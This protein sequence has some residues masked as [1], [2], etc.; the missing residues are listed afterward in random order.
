MIFLLKWN[1]DPGNHLSRDIHPRWEVLNLPF[2]GSKQNQGTVLSSTTG[3]STTL[4]CAIA[5]QSRKK[6]NATKKGP[7]F[8]TQSHQLIWSLGG[9]LI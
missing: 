7:P 8:S 3:I 1:E 6:G 5:P 4:G 2:M 9:I